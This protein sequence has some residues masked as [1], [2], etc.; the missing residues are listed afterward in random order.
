MS[1]V[2]IS[3]LVFG[4]SKFN[5]AQISK[6][7]EHVEQVTDALGTVNAALH[8]SK[9]DYECSDVVTAMA[10]LTKLVPNEHD[11]TPGDYLRRVEESLSGESGNVIDDLI[12]VWG[13]PMGDSISR[14]VPGAF[15]T[16]AVCAGESSHGDE[17]EGFTYQTLKR[18]EFL[19]LFELL[20]IE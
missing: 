19:G 9:N 2:F 20:D 4:P 6:A 16:V 14:I 5:A 8:E 1:T 18:A 15:N 17:P 7:R 11:D 10:V 13:G 3:Y 12:E